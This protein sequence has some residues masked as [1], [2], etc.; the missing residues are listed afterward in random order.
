MSATTFRLLALAALL[1]VV[2]SRT[3]VQRI[4]R[5]RALSPK[6][7]SEANRA[8]HLLT[9]GHRNSGLKTGSQPFIDDYDD[10]Y[11]GNIT[12]GSPNQVFTVVLDTGSSNLWVIDCACRQ[13]A[14]KGDPSSGYVKKCYDPHASSTYAANSKSFAIQYGLGSVS[15]YLGA[16]VVDFGG[17]L[18]I[19]RHRAQTPKAV[20]GTNRASRLLAHSHRN[21]RLKTGSQP[22]ID[23]Y[24]DFYLGNITIGTPN[25]V[26][27]V[28]LDTGSSNLW[29]V[30]CACRQQACKGYPGYQKK[31]YN[32]QASSTYAAR[33]TPF[34][35]QYGHDHVGGYLGA[36]VVNLGGD[37]VDLNQTFAIA[38]VVPEAFERQPLDGMLGLGWPAIS[39]DNVQP[40]VFQILNQ[41]DKPLF[42][43]WLDRHVEPSSG[44]PGGLIT[45]GA[46][47]TQNCDTQVDY[48]PL[49]REAGWQFQWDG[50]SVGKRNF[51]GKQ[52]V[53]SDTGTGWLRLLTPHFIA[54]VFDRGAY[55]Y[56]YDVYT[57]DCDDRNFL[58]DIVLTIGGKKYN[59]PATEYLLD[60]GIGGNQCVFMAADSFSSTSPFDKPAIVLGDVFIRTYC[61]VYDIGQKRIGFSKA[62]HTEI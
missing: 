51:P 18:R 26:F 30:D 35:I 27:T 19:E 53:I 42:S 5:H 10:F 38:N 40:P 22:F 21:S 25:Q 14:C 28:V 55:N 11:L 39:A 52:H 23:D 62:H 44:V 15:G 54:L 6:G 34:S 56:V 31:C 3:F 57:T 61:N 32:P 29:V 37:L 50:F 8:Q 46:V 9:R 43:V 24:D 1:A 16:D 60:L 4:E 49:S 12:I 13:Q 20:G 48:V 33:H 58:P 2:Y 41:L 45:Y 59:I 47:D 7:L 17:D 36:D